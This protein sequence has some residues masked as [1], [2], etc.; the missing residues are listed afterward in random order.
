MA[1]REGEDVRGFAK[2]STTGGLQQSFSLCSSRNPGGRRREC[3][4]CPEIHRPWSNHPYN[5]RL[6]RS[7]PLSLG[8]SEDT[9]GC[10]EQ[11]I[12]KN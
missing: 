8:K 12:V 2:S 5:R 1:V 9:R 10:A 6:G 4:M 3:G 7:K 11:D